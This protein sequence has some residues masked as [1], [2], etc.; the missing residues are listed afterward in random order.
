MQAL[1]SG[2]L[3]RYFLLSALSESMLSFGILEATFSTQPIFFIR[4]FM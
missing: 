3:M 2:T 4:A 1:W